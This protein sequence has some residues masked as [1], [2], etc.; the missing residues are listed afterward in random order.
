MKIIHIG[1]AQNGKN[2]IGKAMKM[3]IMMAEFIKKQSKYCNQ[4][5]HIETTYMSGSQKGKKTI[6]KAMKMQ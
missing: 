6:E 4:H 2:T 5:N 1:D 3:Y